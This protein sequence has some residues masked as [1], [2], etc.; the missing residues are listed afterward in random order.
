ML[1]EKARGIFLRDMKMLR[2]GLPSQ[3]WI[4]VLPLDESEHGGTEVIVAARRAGINGVKERG[5]GGKH[6]LCG[7][8]FC[9]LL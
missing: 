8:F 4:G 6:T 2:K 1:L 3:I 9:Q 7:A 5:E